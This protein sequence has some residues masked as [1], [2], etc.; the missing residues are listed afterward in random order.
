MFLEKKKTQNN[1]TKLKKKKERNKHPLKSPFGS[2]GGKNNQADISCGPVTQQPPKLW[3]GGP[4]RTT[5]LY[6]MFFFPCQEKLLRGNLLW[7]K[8]A[9]PSLWTPS[10]SPAILLAKTKSSLH[11]LM[12]LSH[13]QRSQPCSHLL[14]LKTLSCWSLSNCPLW[15]STFPSHLW[16]PEGHSSAWHLCIAG[17][18]STATSAHTFWKSPSLSGHVSPLVSLSPPCW[19]GC[20][21]VQLRQS[22]PQAGPSSPVLPSPVRWW[23]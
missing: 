18:A 17:A 10:C 5:L 3:A 4:Q 19:W 22:W 14:A 13:L 1:T 8:A 2:K 20:S 12:T 15:R 7:P 16:G 9:F 11:V 21:W 6:F 23:P